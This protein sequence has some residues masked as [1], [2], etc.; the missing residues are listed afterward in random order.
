MVADAERLYREADIMI[1]PY[2]FGLGIKTKVIEALAAGI[3]VATTS[4]G[5]YNTHIQP[6]REAVVSDD[7]SEYA[8]EVIKLIS[9]P[10]LRSELAGN[11]LDYIHRRHDPRMAL[12]PFVEAFEK[13]RLS[14]TKPPRSCARALKHL[15]ESLRPRAAAAVQDCQNDGVRTIAIY[16]A[17]SHTKV[18]VPIWKDLGGP[19]IQNIIV[20]GEPTES[21]LMNLPVLGTDRFDPSQVDGIVL[22]SQEYEQE[23]AGICSERWP[24]VKLYSIWQ[25]LNPALDFESVC[26]ETIPDLGGVGGPDG[27]KETAKRCTEAARTVGPTL[28]K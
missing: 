26:R 21:T 16:G 13:V 6:G 15:E 2:Y 14:K 18:L 1:A 27:S 4:C 5:I 20:T 17:G 22:S 28:R 19:A 23:M 10:S 11:G 3:P 8:N 24:H 12:D 9:Y 7:A 25:S